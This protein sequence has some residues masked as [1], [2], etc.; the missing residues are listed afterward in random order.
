MKITKA[1]LISKHA[2]RG[3]VDLF[4][5]LFPEGVVITESICLAHATEFDWDWAARKLLRPP[6]REACDEAMAP[7]RK[8]RDEAYALAREAY[9]LAWKPYKDVC[10]TARK[11]CWEAR[12]LARTTCDEA[13]VI[14]RK[15]CDEACALA[16]AR[17][18]EG[19]A[20]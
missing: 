9:A 15:A 11:A 17:A 14:A 10:A 19:G 1:L 18:A 8:A 12:V 13:C 4:A 7:V 5:E 20:E 16:F 6:A 2:C 3:Q